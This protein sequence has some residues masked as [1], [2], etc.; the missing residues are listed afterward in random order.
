MTKQ[1][2]RTL[3]LFLLVFSM[4]SL[5]AQ[6]KLSC[7]ELKEK[8]SKS[9]SGAKTTRLGYSSKAQDNRIEFEQDAPTNTHFVYRT[10]KKN[11]NN[12]AQIKMGNKSFFTNE[13]GG[14]EEKSPLKF[15]YQNWLD[16]TKM[17]LLMMEKPFKNCVAAREVN[18][19]GTLYTVYSVYVENDTITVFLNK[20][21]DKIER[22]NG[23]NYAQGWSYTVHF[24]L[25]FVIKEP[26]IATEK[27]D[28]F[29]NFVNFSLFPPIVSESEDFDG[30]EPVFIMVDKN[31]EFESGQAAM[32]KFLAQNIQ[33]PEP[34]R[35]AGIQGTV[36]IGFVVE[37]DGKISNVKLKRGIG[38]DCNEEAIRVLNLMS[39]KW[40]AGQFQDKNVRVAYTLPIKFKLE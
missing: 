13:S 37:T 11:T 31:P 35:K 34:S 7:A 9:I 21:T 17:G 12:F 3:V 18:I 8:I 39:G 30:T 15:N 10:F 32:F 26:K 20:K 33:Y 38:G 6:A 4:Q 5:H 23:R 25:P 28:K 36:Y 22:F 14:W 27:T 1:I 24:D 16:S 40:K 19:T 29:S 2:L